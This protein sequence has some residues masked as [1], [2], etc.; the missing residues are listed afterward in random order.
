MFIAPT[1]T[2]PIMRRVLWSTLL[3]VLAS[4]AAAQNKP[5]QEL[6]EVTPEKVDTAVYQR[7]N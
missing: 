6:K 2:V 3:P 1:I 5:R 7:L 4:V